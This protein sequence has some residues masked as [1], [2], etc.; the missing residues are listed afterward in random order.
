V[1][2]QCIRN[3]AGDQSKIEEKL[4]FLVPKSSFDFLFTFPGVIDSPIC[5]LIGLNMLKL[6]A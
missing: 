6:A 2:L 5:S 1:T 4:S 3:L